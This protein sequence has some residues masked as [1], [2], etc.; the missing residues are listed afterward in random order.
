MG[1][2]QEREENAIFTNCSHRY[3]CC[4][5][6]EAVVIEMEV[7]LTQQ[8]GCGLS[9]RRRPTQTFKKLTCSL[10]RPCPRLTSGAMRLIVFGNDTLTLRGNWRGPV[11]FDLDKLHWEF[12]LPRGQEDGGRWSMCMPC[13]Q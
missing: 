6:H 8:S 7:T 1:S 9:L 4:Q 3:E 5:R 13:P 11:D 2:V 12:I 10:T